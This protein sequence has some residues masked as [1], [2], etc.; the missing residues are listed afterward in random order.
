MELFNNMENL[1]KYTPTELLKFVNETEKEHIDLKEEII[2][3]T[4]EV[5]KLEKIINEK[6]NKLV[7][8]EEKYI[9]LV[10]EINNR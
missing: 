5:E 3:H 9:K 7:Q 1:S 2:I 6:L 10:E 4:H 8:L